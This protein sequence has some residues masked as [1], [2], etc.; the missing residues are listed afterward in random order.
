MQ[1]EALTENDDPVVI[2]QPEFMRR[3]K[4]Q[5]E[6]GGGGMMGLGNMPDMYNLV[7]NANHPL[8][9]KILVE[10]DE[11]KRQ[12]MSKQAVDLAKLSQGMLKGKDLTSFI[13]RSVSLID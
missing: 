3:M 12:S 8:V 9:S 11:E 1:F 7:V 13:K 6:V 2:T 5:Q 10:Q 4:E